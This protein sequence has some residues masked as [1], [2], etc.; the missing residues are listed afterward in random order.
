VRLLLGS[1]ALYVLYQVVAHRAALLEDTL[2][3]LQWLPLVL[4]A[5]YVFPYVVNLG[6][7][8][9]WGR[10]PQIAIVVLVAG[11]A[12][13]GFMATG[14]VWGK[15][16]GTLLFLWLA[17]T[18][19]H[20]GLSFLLAAGIA[21]PGCEMRAIPHLWALLS[22]RAAAEHHCPGPMDGVDRW[23]LGVGRR[24]RGA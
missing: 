17:Y 1:G 4:L 7:G 2:P 9:S 23:E 11:V 12:A 22:G 15:A 19:G 10:W 5:L 8:R 14:A 21:T 20:L 3:D 13:V 18:F 6:W 24:R 16:A